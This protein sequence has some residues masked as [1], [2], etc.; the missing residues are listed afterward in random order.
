MWRGSRRAVSRW[1]TADF[2]H[3]E[4]RRRV[5]AVTDHVDAALGKPGY[6]AAPGGVVEIDH[7]MRQRR[8]VEQH[9]LRRFVALHRAVIVEMVARQVGEQRDVDLHAVQPSLLEPDRRHFHRQRART[10]IEQRADLALQRHRVGRRQGRFGQRLVGK[11]NADRADHR[12]A[13]AGAR[14]QLRDPLRRRRLAVGAGHADRQQMLARTP[15]ELRRKR[16]DDAAQVVNRDASAATASRRKSLSHPSA[17]TRA[18]AAP[19]PP[20]PA[21]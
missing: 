16:P 15:V 4:R 17:S 19:R 5:G 12:A 13:P 7:R 2:E 10:G 11:A 9:R 1:A 6:Q 20:L 18:A 8:P 3:S 14:Q 21:R